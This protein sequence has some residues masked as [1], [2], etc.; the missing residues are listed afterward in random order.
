MLFLRKNAQ[1]KINYGWRAGLV[2]HVPCLILDG[3]YKTVLYLDVFFD[4]TLDI[5]AISAIQASEGLLLCVGPYVVLEVTTVV[6]GIRT[7]TAR[8]FRWDIHTATTT[9]TLSH[10]VAKQ[11]LRWCSVVIWA[12]I[13]VH[14][15][16]RS[17]VITVIDIIKQTVAN[18][19]TGRQKCCC[20]CCRRLFVIVNNMIIIGVLLVML[21]IQDACCSSWRCCYLQHQKQFAI[22]KFNP[23]FRWL[24]NDLSDDDS[25]FIE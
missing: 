16:R 19:T 24:I 2:I 22:R 14:Y 4:V 23:R 13:I 17:S 5:A 21:L 25:W 12:V 15:Y 10:C 8:V 9:V 6:S 3:N 1:L 20:C 18:N 7:V 11:R